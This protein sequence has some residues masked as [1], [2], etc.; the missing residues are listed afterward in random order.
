MQLVCSVSSVKTGIH[1]SLATR[2]R[3][4]LRV[5][6]AHA[7]LCHVNTREAIVLQV[8]DVN[9]NKKCP[10]LHWLSSNSWLCH[11]PDMFSFSHLLFMA[12]QFPAGAKFVSEWRSEA[13]TAG[14]LIIPT[15]CVECL[16]FM[17]VCD[18]E[19]CEKKICC[20]STRCARKSLLSLI[21][22]KNQYSYSV[23]VKIIFICLS[24]RCVLHMNVEYKLC[25]SVCP[26][27]AV[28]IYS[29]P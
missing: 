29:I 9:R 21:K 26:V 27:L 18:D 25:L 24:I 20:V 1:S 2:S 7:R 19:E 6:F 28:A 3:L 12:K 22:K 15:K 4:F 8:G 11:H 14:A 5:C 13:A 16:D 23:V 10:A 17:K